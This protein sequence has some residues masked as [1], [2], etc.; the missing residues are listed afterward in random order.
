[1]TIFKNMT[2]S[3]IAFGQNNKLDII[4]LGMNLKDFEDMK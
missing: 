4:Q 1:M 3:R 2:T